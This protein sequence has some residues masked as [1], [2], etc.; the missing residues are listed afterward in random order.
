MKNDQIEITVV[1]CGDA[2]SSGAQFHSCFHVEYKSLSFLID[3][4]ASALIGLKKYAINLH[5]LDAVL[6]SHFHGDHFGGLP[7]LLLELFKSKDRIKP[8]YIITPQ[9]G[10]ERT[11]QLFSILYA[12]IDS[13]IDDKNLH[14]I[15]YKAHEEFEFLSLK[16]KAFPVIHAVL[17]MP[18]GLRIS[19]DDKIL[20]FS[21]DTEWTEELIP[22]SDN[23]DLFICECTN[24][25]KNTP[26]HLSYS[27]ISQNIPLLNCSNII[28]THLGPEM[29]VAKES[30]NLTWASD[31]MK[32]TF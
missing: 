16:I 27:I 24:Y 17:S 25:N 18:H 1:G 29:L 19:M 7:F 15:E 20:A 4:G 8:F 23:S 30:L 10:K 11:K 32:L 2:F 6:I 31:G 26:G 3:C 21:G 5:S 9:S 28:L 13:I 22:L 14:F 12:G